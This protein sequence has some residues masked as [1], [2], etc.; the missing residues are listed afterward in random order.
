MNTKQSGSVN[1]IIFKD[2]KD[3][4]Y[5]AVCLDFDI[6]EQG[7]DPNALRISI[8]EAAKMHVETVINMNL[9]ETLLNRNAPKPYWNR[10]RK[11]VADYEESLEEAS[12]KNKKL[13]IRDIWV[14]NPQELVAV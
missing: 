8:E 4:L 6:V 11:A 7:E 9:D 13:S 1:F 5:T 10:A 12:T 3:S 2:T 14:R